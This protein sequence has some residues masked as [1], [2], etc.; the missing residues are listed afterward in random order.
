MEFFIFF[1]FFF[2]FFFFLF[3][4]FSFFFFFFKQKTAYE[5]GQWL[6]FR[7]VLFRSDDADV[8]G[9]FRFLNRVWLLVTG[10][11]ETQGS[12]ARVTTIDQISLSKA[13]KDLR[14]AVHTAIKEVSE[15]VEEGYQFN[16]A[17]SELMK[18]SNALK[19]AKQQD[20][21]VYAEGVHTLVLLLA[22]FAPHIAEELWQQ[23]GFSESVH[24][25]S[26]PTFEESALVADEITLVIQIKGK[27][28]GTIAVPASA[29]KD[30]LEQYARESDIAKKYLEGKDIK[31]VIVVPGKL[32]NFVAV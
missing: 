10:F 25:Q 21:D 6:E 14:R 1:F 13:E 17:V 7:R 4:S 22:P 15:D 12:K 29:T 28:R 16:T 27:T 24:R 11:A 23:L 32:V 18:L 31:K 26:W 20:A 3:F 19:D 9:Q 8:E 2:F 30:E 5:I